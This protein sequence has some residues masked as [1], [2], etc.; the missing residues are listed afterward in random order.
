MSAVFVGKT[1]DGFPIE[2]GDNI[3]QEHVQIIASTGRGKTSRVVLPWMLQDYI[4][5]KN[6][7]MIDGKGDR[8]IAET[9]KDFVGNKAEDVIVFDLGDLE[10]SA[11]TNPLKHGSPQQV[12]DRIFATFEFESSYYESV[13]YEALLLVL[14]LLHAQKREFCFRKIFR[15]LTDDARLTEY[16]AGL[17]ETDLS[18]LALSYLARPV[19]DRKEDLAG[20]LSQLRPFAIG[21]V[22]ILVNGDVKGR[23]CFSLSETV[24]RRADRPNK[25]VLL[26]IP[27]LLYQRTASRLGQMFLQEIA[28]ASV[29]RGLAGFL[30]VFLDEFSSFV[31]E[32][33]LQLLNKARSS[34]IGLHI[35]HQS[36]GDLE[37]VGDDFAKAIVTNT[38]VKCVLG[39]NEPETAE[40][41]AKL[42]GTKAS[43]KSTERAERKP[44]SGVE[45]SGIMSIR[46]VEQYRIHPN[47]LKT[48]AK[49]EGVISF[50]VDGDMLIEEVQF[51]GVPEN[52]GGA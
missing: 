52:G 38:N 25:A 11:V 15:A 36:M 50:M 3:R 16:A 19:R 2:L 20:L 49:G 43:Q 5:G 48:F 22:S 21:E 45:M 9:F 33:F 24:R 41:F 30:P 42:F 4:S 35:C 13:A 32:G 27:H 8:A 18:R 23:E 6:V 7:V 28:W 40:F 26:L 44:M 39:V 10:N 1:L 12:A 46:D 14:E 51:A 34:G 37:A 17:G 29:A 47:R 31:Y